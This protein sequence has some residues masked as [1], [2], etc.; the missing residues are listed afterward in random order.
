MLLNLDLKIKVTNDGKINTVTITT[1]IDSKLQD[2][3]TALE[4][5][6]ENIYNSLYQYANRRGINSEKKYVE[7]YKTIK[8]KDLQ[9]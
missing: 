9:N 4:I 5:A 2:V 6:K 3:G 8:F 7:L 1:D